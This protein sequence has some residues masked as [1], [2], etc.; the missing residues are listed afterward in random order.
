MG[1]V[2][3][4]RMAMGTGKKCVMWTERQ[5]KMRYKDG[6]ARDVDNEIGRTGMSKRCKSKGRRCDE[7]DKQCEKEN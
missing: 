4:S 3:G 6:N 5:R 1:W 7:E 2:G